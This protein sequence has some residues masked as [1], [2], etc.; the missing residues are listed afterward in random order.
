MKETESIGTVALVPLPKALTLVFVPAP[1]LVSPSLVR[2]MQQAYATNESSYKYGYQN[3][4]NDYKSYVTNSADSDYP[5]LTSQTY[6]CYIQVILE[7]LEM[8]YGML[9]MA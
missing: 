6:A 8:V 2:V 5:L 3:G 1:F 4:F 9:Q 7:R